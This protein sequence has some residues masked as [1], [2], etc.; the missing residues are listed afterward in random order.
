[1]PSDDVLA[2]LERLHPQVID[3]SLGRVQRLLR[4][5]GNPQEALPPVI[6]VAGTNG[7]GSV[8]AFLRA[9]LEASGR[10][11]HMFTSPHLVRFHERIVIAG[12]E[13]DEASLATLLERCEQ[14]NAG[15]A[16]T[17][18]EITTAAAL[19]AFAETAAD[20]TL[21]E[22]GL[23]GRL[24][25][26]NVVDRP[27]A[28]VLTPIALDHQA[29]LGDRLAQIAFEKAGIL[30]HGVPCA[31][32]A[33]AS[34][35]AAVIAARARALDVPIRWGGGDWM[36]EA[37]A[38][39]M[40]WQ[41]D[42][43]T[44]DLPPPALMGRHQAANA[45]LAVAC[46]D[47]LAGRLPVPP[48]ALAQGAAAASWPGRLQRLSTGRLAEV[49]PGGWELWLDGAHN[50]AA[51][52]ALAEVLAGWRNRPVH[53]VVGMLRTKDVGGF[54]AALAGCTGRLIAVPVPD[55][56]AGLPAEAVCHAANKTGIPAE[57]APGLEDGLRRL[58]AAAGESAR[59]VVTGS[60]YLIGDALRRNTL[61][62]PKA[63]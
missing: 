62:Q 29:Y 4:R 31:S 13:I 7:K 28:T 47:M 2:R 40:R 49:L 48:A 6:H 21:L 11:V 9:M 36:V 14:V 63:A 58:A 59:V 53:L 5:L 46:I 45:G 61:S 41:R 51:A 50:P 52:A 54:M 26:T 43:R 35:A 1:M 57:T 34:E 10:R 12:R 33:Q 37:G 23:G 3:L 16:I 55:T 42:G 17:F 20:V 39:G 24:D 56:A 18:F 30:K 38:A 19:L 25:A 15:E 22:T 60:L 27:M 8:V 44:L 32:A